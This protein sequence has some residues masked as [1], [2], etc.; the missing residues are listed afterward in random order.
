MMRHLADFVTWLRHRS[1]RRAWLTIDAQTVLDREAPAPLPYFRGGSKPYTRWWWLAGPFAREDIRDQLAW[2][3]S[4]GFGGVELAWLWPS[5]MEDA[6]PGIEWLGP[7]WSDL[8]AFTKQEADRLGLGCDFTF[9]SCW[10]FGGS[11]VRPQDAARTFDGLSRQR[12]RGSW[13]DRDED[14]PYVLNHLDR[15]AL[16]HY[17]LAMMPAFAAGLQGS[18]SALFC[19][20]LEIDTRR[21][22]DPKLWARFAERFGYRLEG[23]E[24][25]IDD[26]PDLRYDARPEDT[27]AATTKRCSMASRPGRTSSANSTTRAWRRSSLATT[28]RRS[29]PAGPP[30]PS[31]SS[32]PTQRPASYATRCATANPSA[33]SG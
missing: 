8:V 26:D 30:Y 11:A 31:T 17:A 20:S 5:W 16:R 13:E 28:S 25:Q 32:S 29:G 22:W 33:A 2:L 24:D 14:S 21:L 15:G 9:G 1:S 23:L 7:E 6:E 3:R 18:K 10:P 4:N 12:L 19:D 27:R